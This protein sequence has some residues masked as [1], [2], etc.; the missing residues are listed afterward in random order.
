MTLW[1][2]K[3]RYISYCITAASYI[4]TAGI[5]F[6]KSPRRKLYAVTYSDIQEC[7]VRSKTS[8]RS[9]LLEIPDSSDEDM[10]L[11]VRKKTK[12]SD[13]RLEGLADDMASVKEIA[14]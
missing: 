8:A 14:Y 12:K 4:I 5:G 6:W 11:P 2:H 10:D 9:S 13:D 7:T 3:V 1:L